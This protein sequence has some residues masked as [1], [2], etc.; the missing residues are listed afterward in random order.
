MSADDVKRLEALF[1]D[2][3]VDPDRKTS[4]VTVTVDKRCGVHGSVPRRGSVGS[5][6]RAARSSV[7]PRRESMPALNSSTSYRKSS[8]TPRRDSM[9]SLVSAP[10][11][12]LRRRDSITLGC[13]VREISHPSAFPSTLRQENKT[14]RKASGFTS[15]SN[16]RKDSISLS[17][18][19][20]R[21]DSILSSRKDSISSVTSSRRD[22]VSKRRF[23]TDSLDG[24]KK[25]SFD[26]S[27]R[28]S[29]GSS[30]GWDDPIWE[31]NDTKVNTLYNR[32]PRVYKDE[33]VKV[34]LVEVH[35][36][37]IKRY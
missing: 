1:R 16:L 12:S 13:P 8:I 25:I 7:G 23:S 33:M 20:L 15:P 31:E 14:T 18:G 36:Y 9:P 29:T 22:S 21:R 11:A 27:R 3:K 6:A 34:R 26:A 10:V 4:L 32:K 17:V 28:G 19:S 24:L 5:V 37:Q 35:N 30:G 2:I